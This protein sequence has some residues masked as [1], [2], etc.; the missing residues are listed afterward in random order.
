MKIGGEYRVR[1]VGLRQWRKLAQEVRVDEG[2]L[3]D[4]LAAMAEQIPDAV[5][6]V[7]AS[8]R[9][10]GL[11]PPV[12]ARLEAALVERAKVC[13]KALLVADKSDGLK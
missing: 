3:I 11:A 1:D 8:M 7:R 10:D 6:D 13:S 9:R 5:A 4:R 2:R 12:V